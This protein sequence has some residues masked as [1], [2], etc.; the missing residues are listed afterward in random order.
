MTLLQLRIA[1]RRSQ[2]GISVPHCDKNAA[3]KKNRAVMLTDL[4]SR[5]GSAP[6]ERSAFAVGGVQHG[7]RR[8]HRKY[9]AQG[10]KRPQQSTEHHS[11]PR[12]YFN[13]GSPCGLR[14]V[15]GG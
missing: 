4:L 5:H 3:S 10:W 9:V 2:T 6:I 13:G 11:A 7:V 12:C 14:S 15:V 1:S 8:L